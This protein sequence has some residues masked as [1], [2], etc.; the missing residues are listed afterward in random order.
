MLFLNN[1]NDESSKKW[2]LEDPNPIYRFLDEAYENE[3]HKEK[4]LD[5]FA[6]GMYDQHW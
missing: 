2:T 3:A 1:P 4:I 6:C 5:N